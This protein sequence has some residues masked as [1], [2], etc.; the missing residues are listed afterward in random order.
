MVLSPFPRLL[1]LRRPSLAQRVSMPRSASGAG[2]RPPLRVALV[3]RPRDL[4]TSWFSDGCLWCAGASDTAHLSQSETFS[5]HTP[6]S[7]PSLGRGVVVS[8]IQVDWVTAQVP[9]RHS[10][11]ISGNRLME[12]TPDGEIVYSINKRRSV[13]G[14]HAAN[15]AVRT[16]SGISSDGTFATLEISGNLVKWLQG[17]NAFGSSNGVALVQGSM[18]RLVSILDLIPTDF[19]RMRWA[20]GDV[21]ISRVDLTSMFELNSQSDVM[22]WLRGALHASHMSHRGGAASKGSTLY[23]GK[24]SR[25][26][27]LKAYSKFQEMNRP[28]HELPADITR[29]DELLSWV[30]NKLRIELVLRSMELKRQ[31]WERVASFGDTPTVTNIFSSYLSRLTLSDQYSVPQTEL[32]RLSPAVRMAYLAWKAGEDVR[33]QLPRAS[34]YR[35]RAQLLG[36][37]VDLAVK[38]GPDRSNVVSLVRVLEAKP[39][40]IPDWALG[41][42]LY[43]EPARRA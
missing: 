29:R 40:S 8:A 12:I 28:G 43:W 13:E 39:A 26:W 36:F 37:G 34:F 6:P 25:R 31:A 3:G 17:H 9:C 21:P 30:E 32:D 42:P 4:P 24:N 7:A 2:P 19:D 23:W 18:E 27:A 22:A 20:F 11:W 41:T 38:Q 14:S 5:P 1:S 10:T 16:G 35:Y 15:L 33:S